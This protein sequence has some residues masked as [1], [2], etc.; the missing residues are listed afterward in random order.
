MG[1][2]Q[3]HPKQVENYKSPARGTIE[4]HFYISLNKASQKLATSL[5]GGKKLEVFTPPQVTVGG[6]RTS[7]ALTAPL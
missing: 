7:F 4:H 2:K 3:E 6:Q 1:S 5:M